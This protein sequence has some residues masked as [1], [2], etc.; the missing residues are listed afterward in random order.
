MERALSLEP[1]ET[2]EGRHV[3]E[4]QATTIQ[5]PI[6]AYRTER[7]RQ[8]VQLATDRQGPGRQHR[9]DRQRKRILP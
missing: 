6:G 5:A 2:K 9:L 4:G 8:D 1:H 7:L 3:Q